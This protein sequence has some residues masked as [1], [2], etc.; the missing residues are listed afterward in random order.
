MEK[1]HYNLF[2]IFQIDY[3]KHPMPPNRVHQ[4]RNI[5]HALQPSDKFAAEQHTGPELHPP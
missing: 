5:L 4:V 3:A 1:Q 2:Y